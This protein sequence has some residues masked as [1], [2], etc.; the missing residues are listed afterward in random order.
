MQ[1]FQVQPWPK[2]VG[3]STVSG[4][5]K[6]EAIDDLDAAE[7]VLKMPLQREARHDMYIRAFVRRLG[8]RPHGASTKIYSR[9]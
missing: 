1:I 6:V 7:R 9:D 2:G 5:V 3:N 4:Y 8:A